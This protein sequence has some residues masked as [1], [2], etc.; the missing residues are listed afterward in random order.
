[1]GLLFIHCDFAKRIW[2]M[3]MVAAP[4]QS[5]NLQNF[6]TMEALIT[7]WSRVADSEFVQKVWSLVSFAIVWSLWTARNVGF[8]CNCLE[9]MD[10]AQ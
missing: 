10:S 9:F 5:L 4:G 3:I 8:L 6:L 7:A 2:E 1:M